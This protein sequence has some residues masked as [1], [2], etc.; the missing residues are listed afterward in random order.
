MTVSIVVPESRAAA[1]K[2]W[3]A[4]F[5]DPASAPALHAFTCR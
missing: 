5:P 1:N 2:E 3:I 4:G